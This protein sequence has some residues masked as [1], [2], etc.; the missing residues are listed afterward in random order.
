MPCPRN[1]VGERAEDILPYYHIFLRM[2]IDNHHTLSL[3][4][5]L[6]LLPHCCLSPWKQSGHLRLQLCFVLCSCAWLLQ[7]F[8]VLHIFVGASL[9]DKEVL[10]VLIGYCSVGNLFTCTLVSLMFNHIIFSGCMFSQKPL[11]GQ[12]RRCFKWAD[13]PYS[14]F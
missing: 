12:I 11:P 3:W 9:P 14:I 2:A 7:V 13:Q 10:G 5:S 8:I 6:P 4:L 1:D